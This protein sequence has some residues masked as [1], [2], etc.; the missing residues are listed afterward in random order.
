MRI[1]PWRILRRKGNHS[2]NKRAW[3]L[4]RH[5]DLRRNVYA[6]LSPRAALLLVFVA[7]TVLLFPP[8]K[9][10][11]EVIFKAGEIADR[12]I[13]APFNFEVPRSAEDLSFERASA[14]LKVPPV[15]VQDVTV[16]RDLS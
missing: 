7:A 12:D 8:S 5:L 1:V 4:T 15:Y 3:K 13:I 6:G 9:R 16:E 10:S 2:R 11:Q 14:S